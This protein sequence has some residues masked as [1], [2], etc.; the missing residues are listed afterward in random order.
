MLLSLL[1]GLVPGLPASVLVLLFLV[2]P[3]GLLVVLVL[4][5]SYF[6]SVLANYP[7]SCSVLAF[8]PFGA[9]PCLE[10]FPVWSILVLVLHVSPGN[11]L[12][13]LVLHDSPGNLLM[14]LLSLLLCCRSLPS[15]TCSR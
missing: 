14:L 1:P 3:S 12:L 9:I 8:C 6:R 10:H 7:W 4:H 5:F 11:L 15:L 13:V 2:G